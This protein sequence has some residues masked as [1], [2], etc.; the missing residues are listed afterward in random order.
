[1]GPILRDTQGPDPLDLSLEE[2]HRFQVAWPI[3]VEMSGDHIV[4]QH[5]HNLD[6]A[7]WYL[8]AHPVSAGGFGFR[9]QRVAG[10]M[11]DFFSIDLEYPGG[12]H[13]HSMCR[14]VHGCWNWVGEDF[15]LE[16]RPSVAKK[17]IPDPYE[18]VG[19]PQ[20]PYVPGSPPRWTRP[21]FGP[22]CAPCP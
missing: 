10:N 16:D 21:R 9:A 14:Q 12:V 1:M 18:E 22:R 2:N 17:E 20:N 15:T 11:Y 7:N 5:V 19:Y 3:W 4:E 13:I 6:I 8:D